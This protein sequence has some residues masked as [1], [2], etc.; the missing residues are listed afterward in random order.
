MR[1]EADPGLIERAKHDRAAFG[2]LYDFYLHRVYR[3]SLGHTTSR[4]EAEDITAQTFERALSALPRYEERG[5]PFS[6]WLL[7]IAANAVRDRAR[8]SARYTLSLPAD[9]A[10]DEQSM[11]NA[12]RSAEPGP[13]GWV[14]RWE[15]ADVLRGRLAALPIDQQRAVQLRYYED[16][17]V[18]DI[19]ALMGR[20]EGAVKQLLQRALKALRTQLQGSSDGMEA[21]ADA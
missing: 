5:A 19:A 7:R 4:E 20:S 11:E 18:L 10:H 14:E 2:A 9:D 21:W 8:R 12:V 16:R 15:R 3:F 6:S 17:A 1:E 13:E